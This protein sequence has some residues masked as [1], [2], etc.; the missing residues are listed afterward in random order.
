MNIHWIKKLLPQW[1]IDSKI[2]YHIYYKHTTKH[3]KDLEDTYNRVM[4][5]RKEILGK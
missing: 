1:I 5:T 3:K 2:Y 4:K